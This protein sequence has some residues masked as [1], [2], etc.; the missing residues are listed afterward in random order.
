MNTPEGR[1]QYYG[2]INCTTQKPEQYMHGRCCIV[3][4]FFFSL[5]TM[6]QDG[7]HVCFCP[8]FVFVFSTCPLLLQVKFRINVFPFFLFGSTVEWERITKQTYNGGGRERGRGREVMNKIEVYVHFL[9][10]EKDQWKLWS[11]FGNRIS[12]DFRCTI[13]SPLN[14]WAFVFFNRRLR[15]LMQLVFI[16]PSVYSS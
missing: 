3:V 4:I 12:K 9:K 10:L 11:Y 8:S 7:I 14:A 2:A 1:K 15:F 16:R 13:F 5:I 6:Q